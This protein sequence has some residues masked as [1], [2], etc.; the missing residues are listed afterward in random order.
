[1]NYVEF[2]NSE[3][4]L[5]GHLLQGFAA[6][7]RQ[8]TRLEISGW[9]KTENATAGLYPD[10]IPCIAITLYDDQRRQLEP[11]FIGPFRG[12][13][14]HEERKTFSV[15][16]EAREGICRIG[17]FGATGMAAFDNLEIKRVQDP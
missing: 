5:D 12:S 6:D 3:P 10:Q 4:G 2:K 1:M 8:V 9:V 14:W 15:R 16:R 17:L 11:I 13:A 7:G